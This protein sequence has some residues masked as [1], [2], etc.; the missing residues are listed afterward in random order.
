MTRIA[1][2]TALL[3]VLLLAPVSY[4]ADPVLVAIGSISPFYEDF[5]VQTAGPLENGI[6]GNRLGGIGSALAYL[7]GDLFLALPDRGPN[8]KPYAKCLDDTASY[9]NRFHT[10]HMTLAPSDP[11]SVLPFTLTPMLVAT[12]LLSSR[13]PLV[14]GSGCDGV[15]SGVPPLNAIDRTYYFTGRSDNFEIGPTSTHPRNGRLDTEGIRVSNDLRHVYISDEYGPYVYEFDRLSGQRTRAFLLPPKFAVNHLSAVGANEISG[16]VSGRVGNKGME[17]LAIT[18]NG[19]TLVGAMQ[20]PLLQDGGTDTGQN[21]RLVAIDIATGKTRE[22]AYHLDSVKTTISEILAINNHEFLVDER[23]SK[24]FVDAADSV[25]V[26]KKLYKIDLQ[27]AADVSEISGNLNLAAKAV[28]KE[29][30]L[31]VVAALNANGIQSFAVPAKLEGIAFGQD[32]VVGDVVKH[33]LYI[34]NDNDYTPVVPNVNYPTGAAENPNKFFV[35]AFDAADLPEYISQQI[36]T[37]R[38]DDDEDR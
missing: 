20:S 36:R 15:G 16:N 7:G 27:A 22:F 28:P 8:A 19:R 3:F 31:D 1:V 29:L 12:T 5:A 26:V 23:D 11:G 13:T 32:I 24:G 33:T 2:A 10:L 6:P 21:V 38:R 30:F 37:G 18:P 9:I 14:Y 34:A 4:A 35:F 17:G 25:A